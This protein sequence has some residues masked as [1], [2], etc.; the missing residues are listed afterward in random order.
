MA[1]IIGKVTSKKPGELEKKILAEITN[2]FSQRRKEIEDEVARTINA[3]IETNQKLFQ[4]HRKPYGSPEM[5]GQLGIGKGG[6]ID[7]EKIRFAF[8]ALFVGRD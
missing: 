5:V 3:T 7:F 1:K 8:A 6:S 4:P 2:R